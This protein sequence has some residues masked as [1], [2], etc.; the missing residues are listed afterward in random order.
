MTLLE[1]I[2]DVCLFFDKE[3]HFEEGQSLLLL[4]KYLTVPAVLAAYADVGRGE[5]THS[6]FGERSIC[7]LYCHCHSCN[8][9]VTDAAAVG[10]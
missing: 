5:V 6:A 8:V 9:C 4:E 3:L 1:P 10:F 7:V 2:T